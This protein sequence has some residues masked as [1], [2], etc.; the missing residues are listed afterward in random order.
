LEWGN[1]PA[2]DGRTFEEQNNPSL[3]AYK[4]AAIGKVGKRVEKTRR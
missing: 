3:F 2:S 1:C 4:S